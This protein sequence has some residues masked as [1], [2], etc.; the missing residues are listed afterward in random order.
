M[1]ERILDPPPPQ[2][3]EGRKRLLTEI[4]VSDW[5]QCSTAYLR[6]EVKAGRLKA[7]QLTNNEWRF[8]WDDVDEWIKTKEGLVP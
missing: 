4:A 8:R 5:V 6:R 2:I 7:I 3:I 1:S